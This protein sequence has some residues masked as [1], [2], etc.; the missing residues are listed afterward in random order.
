MWDVY[1]VLQIEYGNFRISPQKWEYLW[2]S[3]ILSTSG[4][5]FSQVSRMLLWVLQP[6][7]GYWSCTWSP[8]WFFWVGNGQF[9][10]TST[11]FIALVPGVLGATLMLDRW[12]SSCNGLFFWLR[13]LHVVKTQGPILNDSSKWGLD[14]L[15][16]HTWNCG[17]KWSKTGQLGWTNPCHS[18]TLISQRRALEIVR[19]SMSIFTVRACHRNP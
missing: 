16:V 1:I 7:E 18:K 13:S 6:I 12:F 11:I 2:T 10:F 15:L 8:L 19:S 17:G 4:W 9:N 5:L 3:R 14:K